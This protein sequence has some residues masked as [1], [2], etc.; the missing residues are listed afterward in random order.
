MDE[1]YRG[2]RPGF[3]RCVRPAAKHVV[4]SNG[5]PLAHARIRLLG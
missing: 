4:K 1:L 2:P 5:L 3:K